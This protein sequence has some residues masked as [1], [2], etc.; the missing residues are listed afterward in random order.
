[1]RYPRIPSTR[2]R[3]VL[4][5][6]SYALCFYVFLGSVMIIEPHMHGSNWRG[7]ELVNFGLAVIAIALIPVGVF[8]LAWAFLGNQPSGAKGK[9]SDQV[10]RHAGVWDRHLDW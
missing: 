2:P 9:L 8:L 10:S 4:A 6:I 1:M 3:F 7:W 5:G